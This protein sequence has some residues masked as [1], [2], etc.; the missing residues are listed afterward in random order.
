MRK[1]HWSSLLK[2][3]VEKEKARKARSD[4]LDNLLAQYYQL[5]DQKVLPAIKKDL[6][7]SCSLYRDGPDIMFSC[8]EGI[9]R[10]QVSLG[11]VVIDNSKIKFEFEVPYYHILA[12]T[13]YT[14][15]KLDG[16]HRARLR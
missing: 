12:T 10:D 8:W 5:L 14:K 9:F 2:L 16:D 7:E 6:P 4:E 11:K 13:A 1:I 15:L 3:S